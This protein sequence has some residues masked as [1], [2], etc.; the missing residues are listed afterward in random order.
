MRY[1][2]IANNDGKVWLLT[3]RNT[4]VALELYQPSWWK[5]KLLKAML[6]LCSALPEFCA[7]FPVQEWRVEDTISGIVE[8]I[9]PGKKLEWAV[10]EGTPSVHQKQVLQVFCGQ[11]ILAYCKVSA[12]EDVKKLFAKEAVLLQNLREKGIGS[13]PRCLYLGSIGDDRQMMV[14]STEKTIHSHI[15]HEWSILHQS[16]LDELQTKTSQSV[17]FEECDLAKG[18][19][20]L[21]ERMKILAPC[22]DKPSLMHAISLVEKRFQSKKLECT[23]MHGDFTP[24]NMFVEKGRLFV[25]DWE[26]AYCRCPVGL[27]RYH[28]FSQTAF[29]ERHWSANELMSYAETPEGDWIDFEQFVSY[30]LLILSRYVG[31]EPETRKMSDSALL[32]FWNQLIILC[33]N[34][35]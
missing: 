18:I 31:R 24:W 27:D 30:L 9:F 19:T 21:K 28:F 14:L 35:K 3:R 16:F 33:Q 4:R 10:F 5:G 23:I 13:V 11:E 20:L 34:K 6:P 8:K 2:R 26:Y 29:F 12:T 15:P 32:A 22:I 25:F 7:P 17:L 1:W